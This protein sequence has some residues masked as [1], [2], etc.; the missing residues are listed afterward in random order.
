[1]GI[2]RLVT[3]LTVIGKIPARQPVLARHWRR[4]SSAAAGVGAHGG[5]VGE[6]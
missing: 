5:R 6:V 3:D 2:E 4:F 1:M